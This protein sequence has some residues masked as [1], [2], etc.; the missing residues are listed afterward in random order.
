MKNEEKFTIYDAVDKEIG[1]T[2]TVQPGTSEFI[3]GKDTY[4]IQNFKES[5]VVIGGIQKEIDVKTIND[6]PVTTHSTY[7]VIQYKT[8][9]GDSVSYIV[10]TKGHPVLKARQNIIYADES[11]YLVLSDNKYKIQMKKRPISH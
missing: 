1:N 10:D 6:I 3:L 11:Y 4:I 9:T 5:M 2:F 7:P 8:F